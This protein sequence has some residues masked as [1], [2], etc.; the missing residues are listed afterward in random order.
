MCHVLAAGNAEIAEIFSQLG[1]LDKL[2]SEN[3]LS[4]RNLT[5]VDKAKQT[6]FFEAGYELASASL[7]IGSLPM[8]CRDSD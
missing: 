8:T 2:R 6:A 1:V 4:L 5:F 3:K 7:P